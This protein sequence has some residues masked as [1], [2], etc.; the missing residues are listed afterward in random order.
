MA[1]NYGTLGS[2]ANGAYSGVTL[3]QVPAPGGG[4][5]APLFDG[6]NDFVNIY[7]ANFAA[8]FGKNEGSMAIWLRVANA[9][10]WTD[11]AA[12][13]ACSIFVDA[14][15]FVNISKDS[16]A[17]TL[18][19]QYKAAGSLEPFTSNAYAVTTW[20][21]MAVTWSLV[22]DYAKFYVN[23]VLI[24]TGGIIGNWTNALI[25]TG[26]AV[27]SANTTPVLCWSGYLAHPAIWTRPLADNEIAALYNAGRRGI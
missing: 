23:G 24:S 17:N 6:I 10:V 22:G 18:A 12:R 7:S 2:V 8:A 5:A 27:G 19:M 14:N 4:G 20:L 15:N 1:N 13:R 3:A 21:H 11:A 25:A 16:V 26:C 9:G